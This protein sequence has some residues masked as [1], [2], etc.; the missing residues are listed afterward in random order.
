[1][2]PAWERTS[3]G[4]LLRLAR[5]DA[6]LTQSALAERLGCSQQAIAQS[7]RWDANPTVD[8][9]RRWAEACGKRITISLR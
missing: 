5:E 8:H 3:S 4:Y 2:L 7:E 1:M 6:G 9:M